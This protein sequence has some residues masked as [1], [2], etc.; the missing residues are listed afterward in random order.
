MVPGLLSE[1][2]K[3]HRRVALVLGNETTRLRLQGQLPVGD[4]G[5][6]LEG[7][8]GL[9]LEIGGLDSR[10]SAIQL[11]EVLQLLRRQGF[12][13]GIPGSQLMAEPLEVAGSINETYLRH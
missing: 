2:A 7:E 11:R 4:V 5:G 6:D 10:I 1:L 9:W 12:L 13:E 8:G 3:Q